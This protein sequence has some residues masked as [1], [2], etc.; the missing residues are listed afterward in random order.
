MFGEILKIVKKEIG[1]RIGDKYEIKD[2]ISYREDDDEVSVYVATDIETQEDVALKAGFPISYIKGE[3]GI[4]D[5][6][7]DLKGDPSLIWW[8]VSDTEGSGA[9][10]IDLL[11]PSLRS[12]MEHAHGS[13]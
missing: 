8:W 5:K 9:L 4:Y 7:R 1:E 3:A 12:V 11:G 13:N 2:V 10:A 6:L